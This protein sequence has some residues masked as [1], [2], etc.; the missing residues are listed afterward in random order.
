M[1]T[2]GKVLAGLNILAAIIFVVLATGDWGKRQSWAYSA[3]RFDLA[4][5]G[6]PIDGT[7]VDVAAGVKQVDR[8]SEATLRDLFSSVGG[9]PVT[10][11]MDEVKRVHDKLFGEFR[12][13]GA[14]PAQRDAIARVLVPLATNLGEREAL[15][16]RVQK[17]PV[18]KFLASDGALER[19]F[20]E[21]QQKR[22]A[23]GQELSQERQRQAIAR[24]LFCVS[25]DDAARQRTAVVVGLRAFDGAALR[26]ADL[27]AG[28]GEELTLAMSADRSRFENEHRRIISELEL[29]A[30]GLDERRAELDRQKE[31]VAKHNVL[32]QARVSDAGGLRS[33]LEQARQ[34]TKA[35]LEE[36]TKEQRRLFDIQTRVG[37][38]VEKNLQLERDIRS[39]EKTKP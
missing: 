29:L 25:A 16:T 8:L 28:M 33:D 19:A 1:S 35:I 3:Y 34:N 27:L 4:L 21:V 31:L 12:G 38:D 22:S 11:Q 7:E 17:E 2:F 14:E 26:Q 18:E 30:Q 37:Q 5:N 39:L 36:L 24:L 10:T 9:N 6:L 23:K 13:S 15:R 32:L 20:N